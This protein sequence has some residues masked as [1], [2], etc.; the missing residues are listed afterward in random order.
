MTDREKNR[1]KITDLK[2]MGHTVELFELK[3]FLRDDGS[4]GEWLYC[5]LAINIDNGLVPGVKQATM[6]HEVVE[7]WN[8]IKELN[9]PHSK[10][11]ILGNC[12][13]QFMEE[14]DPYIFHSG[15]AARL[16]SLVGS[17]EKTHK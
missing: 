12:L 16:K 6:C 14:N 17:M 10:I 3:N 1:E 11:Q 15:A 8:T 5:D 2:I 4:Y 7:A 9:L 13:F